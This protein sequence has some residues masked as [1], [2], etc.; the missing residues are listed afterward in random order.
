MQNFQPRHVLLVP[1]V[2]ADRSPVYQ[3]TPG[4]PGTWY[5]GINSQYEKPVF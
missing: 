3:S 4:K 2:T 1:G 5:M